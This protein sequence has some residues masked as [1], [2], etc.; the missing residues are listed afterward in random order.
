MI[1]W[2]LWYDVGFSQLA[3]LSFEFNRIKGMN[4]ERGKLV[5]VSGL[6][7]EM[8]CAKILHWCDRTSALSAKPCLLSQMDV[9]GNAMTFLRIISETK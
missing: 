2:C 3:V 7:V 1:V 5:K 4:E 6:D 8:C 9:G